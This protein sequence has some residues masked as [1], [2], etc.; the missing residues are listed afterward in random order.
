[1]KDTRSNNQRS[2]GNADKVPYNKINKDNSRK[3]NNNRNE[4]SSGA[5]TV[6]QNNRQAKRINDSKSNISNNSYTIQN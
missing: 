2:K 3:I 1:M 6:I 5:H 4:K